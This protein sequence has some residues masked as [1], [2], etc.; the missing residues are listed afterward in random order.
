M[1]DIKQNVANT[2]F[3]KWRSQKIYIS[4]NND[5]NKL[6]IITKTNKIIDTCFTLSRTNSE[7]KESRGCA[8]GPEPTTLGSSL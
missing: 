7:L 3:A 8:D 6:L 5:N 2:P 4:D 1:L